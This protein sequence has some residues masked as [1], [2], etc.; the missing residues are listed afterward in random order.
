MS[1]IDDSDEG[2]D[3]QETARRR[4]EAIRRA[5][6]TPPKP[7]SEMIGKGARPSGK[8]QSTVVEKGQKKP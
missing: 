2:F 5:L 8:R 3:P 7:H 1:A 6:N 4:D